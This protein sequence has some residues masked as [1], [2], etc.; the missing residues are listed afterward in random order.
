M[1]AFMHDGLVPWMLF[2]MVV[3]AL[4]GFGSRTVYQ[5]WLYFAAMA[6]RGCAAIR[7]K[8]TCTIVVQYSLHSL[9]VVLQISTCLFDGVFYLDFPILSQLFCLLF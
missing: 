6:P 4:L 9:S 3:C 5:V 1:Q 2:R 7:L 8:S